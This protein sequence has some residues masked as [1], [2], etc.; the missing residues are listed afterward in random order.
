MLE[1]AFWVPI[2]T[3]KVDLSLIKLTDGSVSKTFGSEVET[4][5]DQKNTLE[6][7][8]VKYLNEI[9][10]SNLDQVIHCPYTFHIFEIWRNHYKVGDFQEKHIH[11]HMQYSFI[12]YEK[13]KGK[14]KTVFIRPNAYLNNHCYDGD[15][16]GFRE[17]YRPEKEQGDMI[18]FPSTLEHFVEKATE[19]YTTISGNLKVKLEK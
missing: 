6:H 15:E 1:K 17:F 4:S 10:V 8:S 11:T 2:F 5:F 3:N 7:S 18:M 9:F 13:M 14:S 12:I 16:F 19:K